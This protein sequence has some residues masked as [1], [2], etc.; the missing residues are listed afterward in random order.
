MPVPPLV[1]LLKPWRLADRFHVAKNLSEAVQELLARVLTELKAA[2]QGTEAAPAVL[3]ERPLPVEEWRPTPGARVKQAI[4]TRRAERE[5]RF[6]Q[7]E[8]LHK[9]GLTTTE[10]AHRMAISERTVRRLSP[11][12]SS[13]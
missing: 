11:P 10:I 13:S 9:Q 8:S 12:R 5:A 6:Q 7:V 1:V 4:S 2:S 3:G